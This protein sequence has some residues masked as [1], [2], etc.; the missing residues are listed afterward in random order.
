NRERSRLPC[1]RSHECVPGG[2]LYRLRQCSA[3]SSSSL[4]PEVSR[5]WSVRRDKARR[6]TQSSIQ[7]F[8]RHNLSS[9]RLEPWHCQTHNERLYSPSVC[10]QIAVNSRRSAFSIFPAVRVPGKRRHLFPPTY[11]AHL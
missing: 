2:P 4:R 1:R 5:S 7:G 6:T 9:T 3:S 10:S 8:R 11:P